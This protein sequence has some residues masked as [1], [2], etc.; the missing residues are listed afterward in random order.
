M[1]FWEDYEILLFLSG[2]KWS[3]LCYNTVY[4]V[5]IMLFKRKEKYTL[6]MNRIPSHIAFIMDGNGRWANKRKMPR[7]Y[8]HHEGTKTIRNLALEANNLGVKAMTVYAFSTE[9]FKREQSEV[10]YIFKLPKE[11]FSLY[12]QE[13][14]DNNVRIMTIGHLELAPQE[15]QD[16]INDAINK[17]KDNTGLKLVFAFIYGGRD[18]I[19]EATKA[20]CEEYKEGKIDLDNI[21]E[22][23]FESHLM[24][25]ELP[26]VDLMIRS[27]GE[28]RL[29]NFLLWQLSYAEFIFDEAY[30]PDFNAEKLHECIWKYQ[31]RDRRYGGVKK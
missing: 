29:S 9:N 12:F 26:P 18:E 23:Y 21:T 20:I 30:W 19:V 8:G 24:T 5:I 17:T 15:T 22:D 27:S 3:A 11:F 16:I 2:G 10:E 31:N 1:L 4:E 7:T 13:L 14:M 28:C 6:D 25:K